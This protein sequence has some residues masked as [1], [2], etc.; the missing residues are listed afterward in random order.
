MKNWRTIVIAG[1]WLVNGLYCKVLGMVP[2]HQE[3]VGHFFGQSFAQEITFII[4]LSEIALALW[5]LSEKQYKINAVLQ[6]CLVAVMNLLEVS[7]VPDML[8]WGQGNGFFALAFI[9][10]VYVHNFTIK[11]RRISY[12]WHL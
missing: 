8:L 3:I 5:I 6:I 7:F 10:F 9:A 4:G 2:R 1:V 11:N 12:V